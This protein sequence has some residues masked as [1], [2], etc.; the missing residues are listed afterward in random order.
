MANTAYHLCSQEMTSHISSP[1]YAY[2]NMKNQK[3]LAVSQ[4]C[5]KIANF[6]SFLYV[7][8]LINLFRNIGS[9]LANGW[10]Q[11]GAGRA[12]GYA[13]NLTLIHIRYVNHVLLESQVSRGCQT[14]CSDAAL[15][16]IAELVVG[17]VGHVFGST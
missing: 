3:A 8:T 14:Q 17:E 16:A 12:R 4:Y 11:I 9:S 6:Y 2:T 15:P 5:A 13:F 7:N 1:F 10:R